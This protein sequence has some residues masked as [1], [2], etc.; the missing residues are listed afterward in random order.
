MRRFREHARDVHDPGELLA[1]AERDIM[2]PL[3]T[4]ARLLITR[5]AKR[6]ATVTALSPWC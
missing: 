2:A 5:S 6:V 4:E 3:D 1:L